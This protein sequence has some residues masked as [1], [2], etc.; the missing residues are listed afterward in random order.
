MCGRYVRRSD[1]QRIAE[2]FHANPNPQDLPMS[3]ANFNVAPTTHQPII[4]K[5]RETGERELILARWGLVAE[6]IGLISPV[7]NA[8]GADSFQEADFSLV[9]AWSEFIS[10]V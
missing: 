3:A 7:E 2:H 6:R 8:P 1:K 4:R 9:I 10:N 5:R